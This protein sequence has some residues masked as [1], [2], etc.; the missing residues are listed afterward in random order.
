MKSLFL[1]KMC[2]GT[3]LE[4]ERVEERGGIVRILYPELVCLVLCEVNVA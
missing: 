4:S 2:V 3:I 1:S